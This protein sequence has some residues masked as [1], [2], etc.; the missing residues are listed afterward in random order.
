MTPL[1][2]NSPFVHTPKRSISMMKNKT[3][4]HCLFVCIIPMFV[5]RIQVHHE[6]DHI[7]NMNEWI[8]FYCYN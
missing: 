4:K 8:A 7:E 3:N 6:L 2:I 5:F 1:K